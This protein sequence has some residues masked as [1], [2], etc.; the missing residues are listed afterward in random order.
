MALLLLC[1]EEWTGM[2]EIGA[3]FDA[4]YT[5]S[6]KAFDSVAHER[7]HRKLNIIGIKGDLLKWIK[8]FLCGRTQWCNK[9]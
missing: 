2:M 9:T 8:S 7:L 5:D 3:T 6:A 1:L 4:I